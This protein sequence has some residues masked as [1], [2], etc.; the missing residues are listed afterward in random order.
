MFR[1]IGRILGRNGVFCLYGPFRRGGVHT[2][3]SN[4]RFDVALR[5][6]DPRMVLH[7]RTWVSSPEAVFTLRSARV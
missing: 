7:V 6:E 4:E 3:A 2:S 1:G 5:R